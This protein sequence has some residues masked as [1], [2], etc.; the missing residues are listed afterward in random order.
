MYWVVTKEVLGSNTKQPQICFTKEYAKEYGVPEENVE[1]IKID[2]GFFGTFSEAK[3]IS[4]QIKIRGYK[5]IL[6]ISSREHTYRVKISFD[7]FLKNQNIK[8]YTQGSG[9]KVLLRHAIVEFI[10]LKIYQYFLI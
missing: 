10:K 8:I 9:Q 1:P 4:S 3:G 6:L 5:A 7:N 2:E